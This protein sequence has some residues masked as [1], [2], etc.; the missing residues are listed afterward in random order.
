MRRA[1]APILT[2]TIA[3]CARARSTGSISSRLAESASGRTSHVLPARRRR[4][5]RLA[6]IQVYEEQ[7]WDREA[8]RVHE[9]MRIAD[10]LRDETRGSLEQ[11]PGQRIER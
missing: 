3:T 5:G 11:L 1:R 2:P 9:E 10:G 8:R 6:A 7:A 4:R